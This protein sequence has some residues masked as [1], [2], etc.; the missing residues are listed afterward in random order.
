MPDIDGE[1]ITDTL[2]LHLT[3]GRKSPDLGL[4]PVK[5]QKVSA[6]NFSPEFEIR[7]SGKEKSLTALLGGKAA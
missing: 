3:A 5:T 2:P 7:P 6:F 4:M 1:N